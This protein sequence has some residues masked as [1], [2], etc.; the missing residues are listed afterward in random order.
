ME[1]QCER[2]RLLLIAEQGPSRS[3]YEKALQDMDVDYDALTTAGEMQN[4][5][6]ETA[7]NGLLLDVPTMI[8]ASGKDKMRVNEM[9]ERFPVLRL[10]YDAQHGSIRGLH[11][12]RSADNVT[13][14][15]NFVKNT[16]APLPAR[17]LRQAVRSN[18]H[19]NVLL[20]P[21][22]NAPFSAAERTVTAN[23]SEVG[24]FL[25]TSKPWKDVERLWLVFRDFKDKTPA[26]VRVR[27]RKVWG[28]QLE[29][30]GL[31]VQFEELTRPQREELLKF[32]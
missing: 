17:S 4:L 27:W 23:V 11:Y 6:K 21:Q 9:L 2:I 28:E 16:C 5:L 22:K 19:L 15:E 10:V 12:G 25:I 29:I 26:L 8:R 31:G 18:L 30:P 32:L 13:T 24:C 1:P 7:Y 14:L 20:L 3:A